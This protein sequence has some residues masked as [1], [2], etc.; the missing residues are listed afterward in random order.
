MI[1][2]RDAI[3][4]RTGLTTHHKERDDISMYYFIDINTRAVNI[5]YILREP[6]FLDINSGDKINSN[7]AII[8]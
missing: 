2:A 7:Y 1:E 8:A 5:L 6:R 4:R 3:I